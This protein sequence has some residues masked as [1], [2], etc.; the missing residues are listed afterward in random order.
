MAAAPTMPMPAT[1]WLAAAGVEVGSGA[2]LLTALL[3]ASPAAPV[4]LVNALPAAPV[5][6]VNASPAAPVALVISLPAAPV[7]L[8]TSLP[9]APVALVKASPAAPVIEESAEL[10]ASPPTCSAMAR[11]SAL[12]ASAVSVLFGK[13]GLL[14][15][16][17]LGLGFFSR[18]HDSASRFFLFPSIGK[19]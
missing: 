10:K 1:A 9:I 15:R 16:L 13:D 5:A 8:V 11:Q 4:A 6:L 2:S 18:A 12:V 19:D 17:Q 14:A 7:A 3:M